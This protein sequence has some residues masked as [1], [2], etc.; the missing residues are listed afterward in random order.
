MTIPQEQD[1]SIDLSKFWHII[2]KRWV[3]TSIVMVSVFGLAAVTTFSQKLVYESQGK[4]VFSKKDAV[5]SLSSLNNIAD[6]VGD[7]GGLTNTSNPVDTESEII[8]SYPIVSKTITSLGLKNSD[9]QTI[10]SESFLRNLNLKSI[11]GTD[12]LQISYR[13]TNPQEAKNVVNALINNYLESN[14]SSNRTEAK[15]ARDFLSSQLPKVEEQVKQA[16]VNLRNFKEKNKVV[17][18]DTEAKTGLESLSKVNATINEIQGQLAAVETRSQ[19][20]QN[21]MR[22]NTQ[23]AIDLTALS[24]S[25]SVQQ[26]LTEYNSIQKDIAVARTIYSNQH[27]NIVSL[28]LKETALKQELESRVAQTIGKSLPQQT[29]QVGLLTQ[30]FTQEL[31]KSEVE[32]LALRSQLGELQNVYTSNRRRL[33]SLPRLEQEQLQLQRQLSVAQGTYEQLLKQFQSVQIIENQNVGNARLV[34]EGSVPSKAISPIISLN[35]SLGGFLAILLGLGTALLLDA[36][37]RSLKNIEEAK[38]L[39]DLPLLGT[40][41]LITDERNQ[42]IGYGNQNS[43][44]TTRSHAV[45]NSFEIIHTNLNFSLPD[46]NLQVVLVTS[47]TSGEGK[48]FTAA[49]L[50]TVMAARGMRVLL[51]DADMR[52]PRQHKIWKQLNIKGL[53]DIVVNQT[54]LEEAILQPLPNLDLLTAGTSPPNPATLLDSQSMEDLIKTARNNYDFVII[55]SSPLMAVADPLIISKSVDGILLVV[56]LGQV[57]SQ[58]V[59]MAKSLLDQSKVPILGMMLN[60][61]SEQNSYGGYYYYGRD[62]YLDQ[63]VIAESSSS[64]S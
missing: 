47:A 17:I 61:I 51:V 14:I 41:P 4:L 39:L 5:S 60:G 48:S 7:L 50:A 34:E 31:V 58:E 44:L 8:R 42:I 19:S 25:T 63:E 55:D 36:M 30:S 32:R 57:H 1:A 37:D 16:E 29:R 10:S 24:Q 6:K 20:L 38:L 59:V 33:D 28:T 13:S 21:E 12:V 64:S 15:A 40:V 53:S 2:R 26:A 27:P 43:Q 18:L 11:R 45:T 54:Y 56:R 49:N 3:P 23:E 22:L 62:Y 9:G 46:Q 52:R 35:L